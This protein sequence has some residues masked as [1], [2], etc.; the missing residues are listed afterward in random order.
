MLLHLV[1]PLK[2]TT[3]VILPWTRTLLVLGSGMPSPKPGHFFGWCLH[4]QADS[5]DCYTGGLGPRGTASQHQH[6][7]WT[8]LS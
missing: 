4:H 7:F 2:M 1:T 6:L 3:Q 5:L 8:S